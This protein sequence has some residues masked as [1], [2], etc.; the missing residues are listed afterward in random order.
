[1]GWIC[2]GYQVQYAHTLVVLGFVV[3]HLSVQ[4]EVRGCIP[5][6]FRVAYLAWGTAGIGARLVNF[7]LMGQCKTVVS[8]EC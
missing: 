8:P 7:M 1:M 5:I 2:R 3:V 4:G 6:V